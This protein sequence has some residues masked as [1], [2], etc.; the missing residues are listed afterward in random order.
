MDQIAVT[1]SGNGAFAVEVT[2]SG[3][4]TTHRVRVPISLL[5][6][7]GMPD[8]D[9]EQVVRESF[10]FLLEREPNTSILSDFDLPLIA[11]YFPEYDHELPGR[12]T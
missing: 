12:L 5:E 1:A 3:R 11:R 8:A 6:R 7:W 4:T 9:P 10:V 2:Q